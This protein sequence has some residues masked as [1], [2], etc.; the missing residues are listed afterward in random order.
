MCLGN[1]CASCCTV[2]V[3]GG[4]SLIRCNR[5]LGNPVKTC[6]LWTPGRFSVAWNDIK[7][8][9]VHTNTPTL[10]CM[11]WEF[12][13]HSSGLLVCSASINRNSRMVR[14][15]KA[16]VMGWGHALAISPAGLHVR[17]IRSVITFLCPFQL[18]CVLGF[19]P[20]RHLACSR[21][22][23]ALTCPSLTWF[24]IVHTHAYT[25][26]LVWLTYRDLC[27]NY[28]IGR[29]WVVSSMLMKQLQAIH[30][31][32]NTFSGYRWPNKAHKKHMETVTCS[33]RRGAIFRLALNLWKS[34]WR[35]FT[36]SHVLSSSHR[37]EGNTTIQPVLGAPAATWC[38]KRARKCTWQVEYSHICMF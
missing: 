32:P 17:N 29:E 37:Q 9:T 14:L 6:D 30:W 1:S 8:L 7:Y 33:A 12:S 27:S 11:P 13:W 21:A 16:E 31:S 19:I 22:Y 15:G 36:F 10:T 18:H 35:W 24:C 2:A 28:V 34:L 5:F 38:S 26:F 20:S 3:L 4:S 23:F 25:C